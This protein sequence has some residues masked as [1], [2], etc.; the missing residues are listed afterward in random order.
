MVTRAM[1]FLLLLGVCA[2][3]GFA[4]Y[5]A[6]LEA[7]FEALA[8]DE[9]DPARV[10]RWLDLLEAPLD[11]NSASAT[12]LSDL[13]LLDAHTIRAVIALRTQH[14]GFSALEDLLALDAI[15]P[16]RLSLLRPFVRIVPPVRRQAHAGFSGSVSQ[17]VSRR[18]ETSR[19]YREGQY[20]GGP[21]RTAS[22]LTFRHPAGWSGALVL[23]RDPG[24]PLVWNPARNHF[25]FDAVGGHGMWRGRGRVEQV[26]FGQFNVHAG[27][28]LVVGQGGMLG[29]SAEATRSGMRP[30]TGIRPTAAS[31]PGGAWRGVAVAVRPAAGWSVASGVSRVYLTATRD[32]VEGR[33]VVTSISTAG[34]HR[35]PSELQRRAAL[36]RDD[37]VLFITRDRPTY[38][39]TL[40]GVASRYET[41]LVRGSDPSRL[42]QREEPLTWNAGLS[43]RAFPAWGTVWGEVALDPSRSVAGVFGTH[44]R[45]GRQVEGLVHVRYFP[46][47]FSSRHGQ[48]FGKWS[49][50][51]NERGVYVGMLVRP[52][53]HW[54][55]TAYL[56]QYRAPWLRYGISRPVWGRDVLLQGTF[57]GMAGWEA[58]L[59]ARQECAETSAQ[60]EVVRTVAQVCRTAYRVEARYQH[61]PSLH[62]RT[63]AEAAHVR[64]PLGERQ[65]GSGML[66]DVRWQAL[67]SLRVDARV[68]LFHTSDFAARLYAYES[69]VLRG[70]SVPALSGHGMR[71]YIVLRWTPISRAL[72]EMRFAESVAQGVDEMGTGWDAHPG[73]RTRD[74]TLQATLR[75]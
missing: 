37:A 1:G 49:G 31:Q 4:Q 20:G 53:P 6:A 9:G 71:R 47:R 17:R 67:R 32:T 12:D 50:V 22:R 16:E 68:A 66:A 75:W 2:S 73:N 57:T 15:T 21:Y 59:V 34:T 23:A 65:E 26:V 27:E 13:P 70:F 43:A 28:G 51:T 46:E 19:A 72:L 64:Q 36:I 63:R 5:P 54:R 52:H 24:E 18:L 3:P 40:S 14:G 45:W 39:W 42:F 55:V 38:T 25:G 11:L 62:V 69:D 58:H 41:P 61:S 8:E 30:R 44:G 7:L 56:D 10:E 33:P 48:A 29:K 60:P 35:T 74:V